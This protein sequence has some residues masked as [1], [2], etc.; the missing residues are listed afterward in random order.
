[1]GELDDDGAEC[2]DLGLEAGPAGFELADPFVCICELLAE[3]MS[4]RPDGDAGGAGSELGDQVSVVFVETMT[5][6]AR[7]DGERG[8]GELAVAA[9]R[10]TSEE[11]L[12]GFASPAYPCVIWV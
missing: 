8:D 10:N 1:V 7:L 2:P 9:L 11:T 3:S 5:A 12:A 4:V 6:D